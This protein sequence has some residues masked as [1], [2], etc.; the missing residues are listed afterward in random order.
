MSPLVIV[1]EIIHDASNIRLFLTGRPHI[2]EELD[3][4]IT[5][6]AYIIHVVAD[7]GDIVRY[8]SRMMEDD[9]GRDPGLMPDDL[10]LN[11]LRTMMEKASEMF[12]L[13][14]LNIDAILGETSV[15]KRKLMLE[16]VATTGVNLENVYAQTLQRIQEQKGDRSRLGMEALMWI[17]HAERPL[18]IGELC[19][20]L[21]VE[22]GT[23]DLNPEN[24]CP[25]DVVLRSY[26][27][28][29][30]VDSG[31]ST[32]RL[33]H[34]TLQEYLRLPD[35]IPAAHQTLAQACLTYL[36]YNHIKGLPADKVP[37]LRDMPFLEYSSLYWGIHA[38][39]GISEYVRSLALELNESVARLLLARDD[40]DPEK[41]DNH[42][43]TP[44][45]SAC[46]FGHEGIVRQLL[47]R[48]DVKPD[49]PSN[50]GETPLW[51]ACDKGYVGI[52]R[53][54]HARDD[55]DPN[56]PDNR[57]QTPLL[58]ASIRG[59]MEIVELLQPRMI[60]IS[61]PD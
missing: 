37:N 10:K 7:Q 18:T 29:V 55:V 14:A 4:Y 30:E 50:D 45:W 13:V 9:D 6:G 17:S 42:G 21:A 51:I 58:I 34:Y 52:V 12:L 48:D 39:A 16:K 36:N 22:V 59:H 26:L 43:Q 46:S 54:L 11:I 35:V 61:I 20:A 28:L 49:Q 2:R 1:L 60:A 31:A 15:G 44:L 32:V 23:T 24:I 56:M 5:A 40:I 8:V 38:K 3:K 57:G 27:G 33:I 19:Y 25:K 47:A 53:L 41:P